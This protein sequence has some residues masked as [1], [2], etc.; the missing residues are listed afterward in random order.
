MILVFVAFAFLASAISTNKVLLY[1]MAP[2]FLVAVRML[3]ASAL[4]FLFLSFVQRSTLPWQR[5]KIL[6]PA[7]IVISFFTTYFPSNLKAYALA[8]MPSSKMAFFGTLDPFV[9]AL[10][11]AVWFRERL[12]ALQ[13]VGIFLGFIG[14]LFLLTTASPL[15]EQLKAFSVVSLPE[16]AAFW[17]IVIS[18]LGWIQVQQLL[19]NEHFTPLQLNTIIMGFGG[20]FSLITAFL[21]NQMS[22][23]SL[24][25]V[26]LPILQKPPLSLLS[27]HVQLA[28]FLAYTIIIGNMLGYTLYA[29]TLKRYSVT[30]VALAGFSIPL[31]VH[32]FGWLFLNEPL[33]ATF[34]VSC[35]ITFTGLLIFF[36][37]EK[38][39]SLK[40]QGE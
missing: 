17:A 14:M 36:Y 32:F 7:L 4:L 18:R 9:A 35:T 26:A 25:Q 10:Y 19:K 1:V 22:V 5:I 16:I 30:F 28:M 21:R 23:A 39:R 31:L 8:N 3:A 27:D 24:S 12:T 20:L 2:E 34:F 15:E 29:H 6:L 33:S 38:G 40:N 11:S 13:W 37:H